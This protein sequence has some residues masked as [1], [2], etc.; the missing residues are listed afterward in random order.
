MTTFVVHTRKGGLPDD[1][2]IYV[3]MASLDARHTETMHQI[4]MQIQ[5]FPELDVKTL[6]AGTIRYERCIECAL[7]AD[8]VLLNGL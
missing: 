7:Q 1:N 8:L 3:L 2:D 5:C 4:D 6:V